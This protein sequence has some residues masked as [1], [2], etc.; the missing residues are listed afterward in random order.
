MTASLK[1]ALAESLRQFQGIKPVDLVKQRYDRLCA[2]GKF[3]DTK[4]TR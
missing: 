2:F 4:S 3:Q 1:R